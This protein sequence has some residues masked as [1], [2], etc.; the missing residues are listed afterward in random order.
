MRRVSF[1]GG[2]AN[3]AAATPRRIFAP[4]LVDFFDGSSPAIAQTPPE[5]FIVNTD[6]FHDQQTTKALTGQI[7]EGWHGAHHSTIQRVLAGNI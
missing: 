7:D 4:Q 1:D 2:I 5:R 3:Q 6:E